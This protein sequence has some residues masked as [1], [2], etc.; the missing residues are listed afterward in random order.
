MSVVNAGIDRQANMGSIYHF[1][2]HGRLARGSLGAAAFWVGLRQEIYIAVITKG[3]VRIRLVESLVDRSLDKTD[4]CTWANR[5]IVHCADVL[6]YCYGEEANQHARWDEL[7][8]WNQQWPEAAAFTPIFR[9]EAAGDEP[10]PEIWYHKS[11]QGKSRV[12][13]V[14]SWGLVR[15]LTQ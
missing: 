8:R 6:N 3:M 10:I 11:C 2:Q 1:V 5:A 15:E 12:V 9:Q 4:D 13:M 14:C 7:N